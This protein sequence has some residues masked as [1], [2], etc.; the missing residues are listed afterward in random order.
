MAG[1]PERGAV[2]AKEQFARLPWR[3]TG[4]LAAG[5]L[6]RDEHVLLIY[7]LA[8]I[9]HDLWKKPP[10]ERVLIAELAVIKAETSWRVTIKRVGQVLNELQEKHWITV[11]SRAGSKKWE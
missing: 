9:D 7:L 6:T 8:R 4:A 10:D 11:E 1:P 3:I 2:T 5:E